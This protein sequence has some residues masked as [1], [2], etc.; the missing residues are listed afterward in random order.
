MKHEETEIAREQRKR[1]LERLDREIEKARKSPLVQ[2]RAAGSSWAMET[3]TIK[4]LQT[5]AAWARKPEAPSDRERVYELA[6]E[7]DGTSSFWDVLPVRPENGG[8]VAWSVTDPMLAHAFVRGAARIYALVR[9]ELEDRD[10]ID[11]TLDTA[12][13]E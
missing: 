2:A 4:Q 11:P 1:T 3:A 7:L 9:R 5:A 10:L 8:G 13:G 12:E 6:R